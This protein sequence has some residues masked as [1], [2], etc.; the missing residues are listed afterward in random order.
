MGRKI[1]VIVL[2]ALFA[3]SVTFMGYAFWSIQS[4][5]DNV[6]T[7]ASYR[8]R[9]EET[10]EVP[11]HVNPSESVEKMVHVK[12]EGT[13]DILVR[14]SVT[15]AFGTRDAQGKLHVADELNPDMI[16]IVF[17]SR[18]WE[19]RDDGWFYYKKIL[20]AQET[21]EE[22]LMESYTLSAKAGNEYKG[23]DAEIVICME[24]VQAD[25]DAASVW[26]VRMEELGIVFPEAPAAE[27]TTVTYLGREQGFSVN[28]KNTDLFAAFKNLTPGCGRT[29]KILV[30]NKSAEAVEIFLRA[31][32]TEQ[33][34]M[35]TEQ[36]MLVQQLLTKY[37]VIEIR[38]N[39]KLL[40]EGAV[41]GSG[42][43]GKSGLSSGENGAF[44]QG[45]LTSGQSSTVSAQGQQE[46]GAS[47]LQDISLGRFASGSKKTLTVNLRLSPEMDNRFQKLTGKVAWIFSARGEDGTVTERKVPVTADS[48]RIMMWAALLAASMLAAAIAVWAERRDR[49]NR[50]EDVEKDN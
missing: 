13:V 31:E 25:R 35:S 22:P 45:S 1:G 29:Q 14:V 20:R 11:A 4:R 42:G 46:D 2:T 38:E 40:Y 15:K 34:R 10:Y 33:E 24:S 48:T 50:H 19:Q 28:T 18:L 5:T 39:G 12:N 16:E 8:A 21:T 37:A 43:A 49:R 36:A 26:G 3:L 9:I 41:C 17:N 44:G 30:E 32:Q 7:M 23:R 47:M 27:K 6:L